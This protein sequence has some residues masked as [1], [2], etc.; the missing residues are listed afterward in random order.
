[1][2]A[3]RCDRPPTPIPTRLAAARAPCKLLPAPLSATS[4]TTFFA[5]NNAFAGN[6]FDLVPTTNITITSFE[7]NLDNAG[8]SETITIY[9]RNGTSQGF[10]SSAAGWT[11]L[12]SDTVTSAGLDTPTPVAIGGLAL[13]T[14]FGK[15]NPAFT[16]ISFFPRQWNGTV[17]YSHAVPTVP[18]AGLVLLMM[19]LALTGLWAVRRLAPSPR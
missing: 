4:L 1:M 2:T 16:G 5:S 7:V 17:Y 10:E 8:A 11:S 6:T 9:W 15:G 19:L 13:T 3:V 14:F 12:G 18:Q